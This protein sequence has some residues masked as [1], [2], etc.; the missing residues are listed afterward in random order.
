MRVWKLYD[1]NIAKK[2]NFSSS[3]KEMNAFFS[4]HKMTYRLPAFHM[5]MYGLILNRVERE[6]EKSSVDNVVASLASRDD[7]TREKLCARYPHFSA[8]YEEGEGEWKNYTGELSEGVG[9]R[10]ERKRGITAAR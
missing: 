1:L 9:A 6:P 3:L 10:L 5:K 4:A 2:C 7:K 8:Y